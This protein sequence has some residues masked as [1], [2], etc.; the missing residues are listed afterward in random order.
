MTLRLLSIQWTQPQYAHLVLDRDHVPNMASVLG[1]SGPP[2]TVLTYEDWSSLAWYETGSWVVAVKPPGYAK[3][4]F[5]PAV[6]TGR[7]QDERRADLDRALDGDPATLAAVAAAYNADRILLARRGDQWGVI[8]QVAAVAASGTGTA[9][10]SGGTTVVDGNGWDA[11]S[12][13]AGARLVM[14]FADQGQPI[15]LEIRFLGEEANRAVPDRHVRLVA[16]GGDGDRPLTEL[17]VPATELDAWQVVKATVELR[18]G[19]RLAI[20]AVDPVTV[21]S[22]LGFVMAAPPHGW[23]TLSETPDSVLLGRLP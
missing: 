4:A 7:S 14:T 8:H 18:P 3:L 11:V 22:T 9:I 10:T 23:A 1:D 19:E 6:F 2:A 5:D 21:Q 17:V 16:V 15:A 20:E 12:L 13:A